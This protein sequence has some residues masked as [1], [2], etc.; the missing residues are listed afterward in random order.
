MSPK[1]EINGEELELESSNPEGAEL[2]EGEGIRIR[3]VLENDNGDRSQENLEQ[4]EVDVLYT[5]EEL[6]EAIEELIASGDLSIDLSHLE[7]SD[8][9]T[10]ENEEARS[11]S[12]QSEP[13]SN[14]R[15]IGGN[16]SKWA[17]AL[18]ATLLTTEIP[19]DPLPKLS[20][21]VPSKGSAAKVSPSITKMPE[22]GLPREALKKEVEKLMGS[23]KLITSVDA[24]LL[25]AD[26]YTGIRDGESSSEYSERT[27]EAFSKIDIVRQGESSFLKYSNGVASERI[28]WLFK[29]KGQ[30]DVQKKDGT[31]VTVENMHFAVASD[32]NSEE[33]ENSLGLELVYPVGTDP[34][35]AGQYLDKVFRKRL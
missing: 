35:K 15:T 6:T 26:A 7:G 10:E 28:F 27:R 29:P 34:K 25:W 3:D 1:F 14:I 18:L 24:A 23:D 30:V 20:A 4:P 2:P 21:N 33:N 5:E 17:A 32:H 8:A 19:A 9:I 22:R 13:R 16:A 11:P 12:T 31:M